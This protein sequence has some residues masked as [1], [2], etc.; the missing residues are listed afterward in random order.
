[1]LQ[2][3]E[4]KS[5]SHPDLF[6]SGTKDLGSGAARTWGWEP[7]AVASRMYRWDVGMGRGPKSGIHLHSIIWFQTLSWVSLLIFLC[8][9]HT[10][11]LLPSP[12]LFCSPLPP[13]PLLLSLLWR[14]WLLAPSRCEVDQRIGSP[15]LDSIPHPQ[16]PWPAV[17]W[18]ERE[19][20]D[21]DT[22]RGTQYGRGNL[23]I[24]LRKGVQGAEQLSVQR[25]R[26]TGYTAW[27]QTA[28]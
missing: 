27:R 4:P 8:P 6:L 18:P 21:G 17:P 7:G 14:P 12:A 24:L 25:Q 11:P 23:R 13:F 19:R 5:L 10:L 26:E 9:S 1:M 28:N 3:L 22:V 20:R 15:G 16:P 2:S